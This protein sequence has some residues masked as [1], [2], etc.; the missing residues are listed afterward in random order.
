MNKLKESMGPTRSIRWEAAK[1]D[2]RRYTA[3]LAS[4]PYE[5]FGGGKRGLYGRQNAK[6][7]VPYG[8]TC[9]SAFPDGEWCAPDGR[10][11]LLLSAW[12]LRGERYCKCFR[13]NVI[14]IVINRQLR[15][16]NINKKEITKW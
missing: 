1:R 10:G 7:G 4:G 11:R 9:L 5:V 15:K 3:F 14:S 2:L 16:W 12:A 6:L 13:N 8:R